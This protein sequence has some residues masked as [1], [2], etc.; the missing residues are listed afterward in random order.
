MSSLKLIVL[1][2]LLALL[3]AEIIPFDNSAIDTIFQQKKS[4]LFLFVGD[5][6][7]EADALNAFRTF[8]ET[9]P[10]VVL[11]LSSKNDGHGL[12][13]RLAEYVGVDTEQT[14][15]VLLLK[16]GSEKYQFEGEITAEALADFVGK[17]VRGELQ[18]FY[19]S[20][21]IPEKNDLGD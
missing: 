21:P 5:E 4:A 13:D 10:E 6:S 9:A 16:D 2:A 11:T 8:D 20:A 15:A 1:V 14:P 17:V 7:A 3:Q 19:K 18:P 12:F